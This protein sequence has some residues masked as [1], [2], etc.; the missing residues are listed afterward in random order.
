MANGE[1][2]DHTFWIGNFLNTANRV[3]SIEISYD[4]INW[5]THS[6][7]HTFGAEVSKKENSIVLPVVDAVKFSGYVFIRSSVRGSVGNDKLV[8][9]SKIILGCT[10]CDY[11]EVKD[12][13]RNISINA[14]ET[15]AATSQGGSVLAAGGDGTSSEGGSG[16]GGSATRRPF[17][18][19]SY[20]TR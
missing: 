13:Q 3:H 19:L 8:G 12:R 1:Q 5:E 10:N 14:G 18:P 7:D 11:F 15:T 16:G 4:E 6:G 20:P 17:P 2:I 9:W